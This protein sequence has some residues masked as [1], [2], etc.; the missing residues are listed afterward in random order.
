MCSHFGIHSKVLVYLII[1]FG[2][3]GVSSARSPAICQ[4]H[5]TVSPFSIAHFSIK[6]KPCMGKRGGTGEKGNSLRAK[7]SCLLAPS[8]RQIPAVAFRKV[9]LLPQFPYSVLRD[10]NNTY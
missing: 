9:T 6:I 2:V 3:C 5:G 7:E 10:Y 4:K 1:L 8:L